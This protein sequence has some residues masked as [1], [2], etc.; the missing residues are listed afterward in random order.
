M[1]SSRFLTMGNVGFCPTLK[2]QLSTN[3]HFTFASANTGLFTDVSSCR[4]NLQR[5]E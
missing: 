3:N 2:Q 1:P 5:M 4:V